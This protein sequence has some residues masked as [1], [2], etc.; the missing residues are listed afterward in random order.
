MVPV[1]S[2]RYG[3]CRSCQGKGERIKKTATGSTDPVPLTDVQSQNLNVPPG[4]RAWT[5]TIFYQ[6]TP[7]PA[8]DGTGFSG[9]AM[10]RPT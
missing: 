6:A 3:D 1:V 10:E 2:E 7:C 8:C 5:E 9:D 4:G